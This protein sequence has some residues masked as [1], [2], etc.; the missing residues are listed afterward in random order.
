MTIDTNAIST[1]SQAIASA[2]AAQNLTTAV[3]DRL[4]LGGSDPVT[5][6]SFAFGTAAHA[7]MALVA[8]AAS[9]LTRMRGGAASRVGIDMLRAALECYTFRDRRRGASDV[10]CVFWFVSLCLRFCWHLRQFR[11]PPHDRH[12]RLGTFGRCRQQRGCAISAVGLERRWVGAGRDASGWSC[13]DAAQL[14]A[15]VRSPTMRDGRRGAAG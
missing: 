4:A 3:L 13:G 5:P 2:W 1:A 7:S 11:A 9:E 8:L 14:G 15:M 10:R 12:R 6:P